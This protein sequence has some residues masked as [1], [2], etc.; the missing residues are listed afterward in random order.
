MF[1]NFLYA[2]IG[3][4]K[5][6]M[7]LSV[8]SVLARQ[9][10]DPWQEAARLAVLPGTTAA[11]RLASMI[12]ASTQLDPSPIAARL[13]SLLPRTTGASVP[14]HN[15]LLGRGFASNSRAIFYALLIALL[16]GALCLAASRRPSARL[17]DAHAP[18]S[19]T[20]SP[21]I[22]PSSSGQ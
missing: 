11:H 10:L 18:I 17:D 1:D 9:G 12:T 2:P 3:E 19:R 7:L 4:D 22:P 21:Q 15:P 8:L 13:I 20:V 16:F 5:N 14:L 6:G